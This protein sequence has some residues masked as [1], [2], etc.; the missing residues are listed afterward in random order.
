MKFLD[1]TGLIQWNIIINK[2]TVTEGIA[3]LLTQLSEKRK[4]DIRLKHRVLDIDYSGFEHVLLKVQRENGDIEE[5]KA[6]FV[7]STLPIG[8]LKKYVPF[9]EK[10]I[11]SKKKRI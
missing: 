3:E 2:I 4:L 11:D 10:K 1:Y 8:V 6:A 5:M 7:V 9:F